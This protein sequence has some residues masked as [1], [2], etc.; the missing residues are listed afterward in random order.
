M[1]KQ[2][3]KRYLNIG[4]TVAILLIIGAMIISSSRS[5]KYKQVTEDSKDKYNN[6]SPSV[7]YDSLDKAEVKTKGTWD[8]DALERRF[9]G[10][11]EYE[12][13]LELGEPSRKKQLVDGMRGYSYYYERKEYKGKFVIG[14]LFWV[15]NDKV[16]EVRY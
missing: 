2:K 13:R 12:L 1:D 8:L 14:A 9:V 11:S 7:N 3:N 10:K 15:V 6:I 4:V 16:M 5:Q